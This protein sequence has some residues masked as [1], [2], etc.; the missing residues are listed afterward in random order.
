MIY[1]LNSNAFF[2]YRLIAYVVIVKFTRKLYYINSF[3]NKPWFLHVCSASLLKILWKK[4]KLLVT[5]NFSFFHCVLYTFRELSGE[6]P[7]QTVLKKLPSVI[8]ALKFG[9]AWGSSIS[10]CFKKTA[11]CYNSAK[12]RVCLG[13]LNLTLF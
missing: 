8:T 10:H 12:V 1:D 6:A 5:S 3:Q 4:E 2:F 11:V 9:F 13:K 7:S